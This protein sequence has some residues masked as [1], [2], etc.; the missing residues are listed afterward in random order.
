MT[1]FIKNWDSGSHESMFQQIKSK[2]RSGPPLRQRLSNTL[3]RLQVVSH[4]LSDSAAKLEQRAKTF[5]DKCA[6]AQIAKD[7]ERAT[8]YANECAEIRK[9]ARIVLR[10]QLTIEQVMIRLET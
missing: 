7:S 5:F 6:D 8:I 3:Y 1:D 9:M 4:N 10:S 2:I